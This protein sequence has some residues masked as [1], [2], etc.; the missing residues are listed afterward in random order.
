VL[1]LLFSL[2][3]LSL[4]FILFCNL[5]DLEV[6]YSSFS[7]LDLKK[8]FLALILVLIVPFITSLRI[9]FFLLSFNI[10]R[11][12]NRCYKATFASLSLNILL[13]ARGGDIIKALFLSEKKNEN[14]SIIGVTVL[15]RF[16]DIKVLSFFAFCSALI[17]NDKKILFLSMI[18]VILFIFILFLIKILGSFNY[19]K[20]KFKSVFNLFKGSSILPKFLI[21]G[22]L[23]SVAS[24][25]VVMLILYLLFQSTS[26]NISLIDTI[27]YSP[28][29]IFVGLLPLSISGIGTRDSA[30]VYFLP[31]YNIESV[32]CATFLYTILAYW[33][34]GILGSLFCGTEV[35]RKLKLITKK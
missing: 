17:V 3:G 24:W 18:P 29:S 14:I 28:I 25:S 9:Y 4:F 2:A 15:E 21:L 6:F 27:A 34:L 33:T 31:S 20:T 8:L 23:C 32:L 7:N 19:I 1:K 30:F 5:V 16:I 13:P 22:V 11:N 12:Y 10:K 35:L 26:V